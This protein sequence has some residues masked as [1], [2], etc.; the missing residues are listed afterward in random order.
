MIC[1]ECAKLGDKSTVQEVDHELV[2]FAGPN[3]YWDEEGRPHNHPYSATYAIYR[4]SN[5]HEWT[6]LD[7]AI[8]TC[9]TC[10][11]IDVNGLKVRGDY[12]PRVRETRTWDKGALIAVF[13][14]LFIVALVLILNAF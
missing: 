1:D 12:D 14:S 11:K 10:G 8:Y 3:R 9:K 6:K 5:G 7:E 13:G 2:R 4:C